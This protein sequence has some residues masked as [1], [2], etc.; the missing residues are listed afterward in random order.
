MVDAYYV[1]GR[2]AVGQLVEDEAGLRVQAAR[3]ENRTG[4]GVA[5]QPPVKLE[6]R[7]PS[8]VEQRMEDERGLRGEA[9]GP[10][11]RRRSGVAVKARRPSEGRGR[12][13]CLMGPH[14]LRGS[15][16]LEGRR[17]SAVLIE[18]VAAVGVG[19]GGRAGV[20]QVKGELGLWG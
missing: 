12:D 15:D 5:T 3:P 11:R 14:G 10:E 1:V 13:L 4:S 7:R 8:G 17:E 16:S 9:P 20:E 6:A 2:G 19:V 18:T